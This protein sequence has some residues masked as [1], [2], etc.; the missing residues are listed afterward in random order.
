M[1]IFVEA[2]LSILVVDDEFDVAELLAELL[3]TRGHRVTTAINGLLARALLV[4]NDY[5]LVIT[6]LMMPIVDGIELVQ[7]MRM[8]DRLAGVPVILTSAQR[9]LPLIVNRGL[10]QSTLHKPFSPRAL[11]AAIDRVIGK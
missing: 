2:A 5:D 11:Y 6:D 1:V 9:D 4:G 10:V 3:A 7:G 8:D